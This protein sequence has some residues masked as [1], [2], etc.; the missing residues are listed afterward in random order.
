M[1]DAQCAM[2]D[3]Q[4]A[5]S[6]AQCVAGSRLW[7]SSVISRQ[8]SAVAKRWDG[9]AGAEGVVDWRLKTED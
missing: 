1:R 4:C 3:A 5:M 6:D 2:R 8:S 7:A 9:D